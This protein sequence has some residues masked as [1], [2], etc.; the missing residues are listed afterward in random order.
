M[1][2]KP[3]QIELSSNVTLKAGDK[4]DLYLSL[5]DSEC[6]GWVKATVT[7]PDAIYCEGES[8][9]WGVRVVFIGG[10]DSHYIAEDDYFVFHSDKTEVRLSDG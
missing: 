1:E 3:N 8:R 5:H 10:D 9:E 2:L 7:D 4:I 6:Y